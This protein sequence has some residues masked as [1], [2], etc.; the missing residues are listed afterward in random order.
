[1]Y[2]SRRSED[3][4]WSSCF[5]SCSL[6]FWDCKWDPLPLILGTEAD[7]SSHNLLTI[8]TCIGLDNSR[9]TWCT[10]SIIYHEVLWDLLQE[11]TIWALS[12]VSLLWLSAAIGRMVAKKRCVRMLHCD[13]SLKHTPP[14]ES[15][16]NITRCSWF[17]VYMYVYTLLKVSICIQKCHTLC[18]ALRN[19]VQ[20]RIYIAIADAISPRYR[21]RLE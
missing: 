21:V 18:R 11:C 2:V 3:Q 17:D 15:V 12:A 5:Y 14:Q 19:H 10:Q 16:N 13:W 1:M 6:T 20:L 7:S 4:F 8:H 9:S